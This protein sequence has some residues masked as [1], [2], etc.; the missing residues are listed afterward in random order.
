MSISALL[1]VFIPGNVLH[2]LDG[3]QLFSP[4]SCENIYCKFK[5]IVKV[6]KLALSAPPLFYSR[7]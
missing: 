7:H 1:D 2:L 4:Y 3:E 5:F 6:K